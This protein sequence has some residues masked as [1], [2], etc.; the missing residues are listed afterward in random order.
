M[1]Y[2]QAFLE[3]P[4]P[5]SQKSTYLGE[6]TDKTD[7]TEYLSTSE[8]GFV[9]FVGSQPPMHTISEVPDSVDVRARRRSPNEAFPPWEEL[10]D[11]AWIEAAKTANQPWTKE[12][13][14]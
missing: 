3:T 11:P 13:P 9:G 6:G 5:P 7:K 4:E 10:I 14:K 12:K 8:G 1:N 2:L